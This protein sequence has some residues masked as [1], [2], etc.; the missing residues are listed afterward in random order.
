MSLIV[1][2]FGGTSV[3]DIERIRGYF[4]DAFRAALGDDYEIVT[5]P[6]PD[7]LKVSAQVIDMKMTSGGAVFDASG[8]LS[9]KVRSGESLWSIARRYEVAVTDLRSWNG[10]SGSLIKPGQT[11]L[12]L[13][14][15]SGVC[16]GMLSA[17]SRKR[18]SAT[19][20]R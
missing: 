6:A 7:V 12:P 9:H 15:R 20:C 10:L 13:H 2:K 19:S 17:P 8:R 5:E 11:P 3:A 1:Q 16:P 4:R 14:N 18:P